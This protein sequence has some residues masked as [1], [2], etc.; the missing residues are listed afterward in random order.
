MDG[1]QSRSAGFEQA[2]AVWSRRKWLAVLT[3]AAAFSAVLSLVAFL[4]NVYESKATVIIEREQVSETF[5]R[6]AV[7]G[8]VET[9]LRTIGEKVLSRTRLQNLINLFG[10]FP[11]MRKKARP[12]ELAEYM[13]KLI[14]LELKGVEETVG[15]RATVA[16]VLGFRG[17]DPHTVALVTNTLASFFVEENW[18]TRGRQATETADFFKVQLDGV[19]HRLEEQELRLKEVK[20]RL[21]GDVSLQGTASLMALE[22]LSGQLRVNMDRLTRVMERRETLAKQLAEV[23]PS[24]S[25][26]TGGAR[27]ERSV[28]LR[29]ELAELR[30]Q[31]TD[32]Y[33][34]VIRLR[35]EIEALER[36][37]AAEVQ[38]ERRVGGASSDVSARRLK[39]ALKGMEAEIKALTN[40][41]KRLQ[42]TIATYQRGVEGLPLQERAP[43][44]LLRDY[45]MT[46]EL[47]SSLLKRYADAQQAEN[48]ERGQKGEKFRILDPAVASTD[49]VAPNR[50][51][52]FLLGLVCSFALAAGAVLLAEQLDG[53]FHSVDELRS[54]TKV[55]VLA[56]IPRIVTEADVATMDRRVRLAAFA[57]VL[58]LALI[59]MVS[60]FIA[61]GNE[62]LV[63]MLTRGRS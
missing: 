17:K 30:T 10:L 12:E 46:K 63:Y 34:D 22:R 57:A 28:K 38:D 2:L 33:P 53:S 13:R 37:S 14:R 32:Q 6:P 20:G 15:P 1:G 21:P 44:D 16:F 47:Y 50:P 54:F 4:P 58:S 9:R 29:R 31:Y 23:S 19:R 18:K 11:S 43:A 7:T 36:G 35:E 26:G 27:S 52:L 40:E 25:T 61:H 39:E 45:E 24:E 42:D 60:Y 41:E 62:A 5:V 8:E 55:P 3:F 56:C 59:V 51:R 49:P 48:V